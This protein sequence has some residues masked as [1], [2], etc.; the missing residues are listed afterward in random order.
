[1]LGAL[2]V[3]KERFEQPASS[4]ITKEDLYLRRRDFIK[5]AGLFT[6]TGLAW[7]AGLIALSGR[8]EADPPKPPSPPPPG[9][10]P[11]EIVKRGE[12]VLAEALTPEG[13]VTTYNNF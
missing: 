5:N 4:E 11:L 7:G 1:M 6:A 3:K 12:F 9:T 8:G 10:K 13:S 2:P